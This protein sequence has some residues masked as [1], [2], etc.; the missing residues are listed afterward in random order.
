MLATLFAVIL[1]SFIGVGLPDSVLG[2]AWPE[3]YSEFGLPISMAGYIS[4]S[5][6]VGTIISSILSARLINKFGTGLVTAAS[7]LLTAVALFGY[8]FT[9]EPL[10]FFILAVPLGLGAGA[11]DTGLN[12]FV[13]THY[14]AS[15]MCFLHCSYGL[16]VMASPLIMSIALRGGGWRQGYIIVALIQA[17]ITLITFISLPMW[18]KA[19]KTDAQNLFFASKALTLKELV[20]I[21]GVVYSA[22][23]F[24][25]ICALEL[26]AGG[27]CSS[28]FVNTRGI[29]SENAALITMLFYIGFILGRLISGFLADR[30]GSSILLKIS[31]GLIIPSVI[32][33]ALPL[34]IPLS[35]GALFFTGMAIGPIYPNLM[36]LTPKLFGIETA[37]AV[38]G[39]Q[40]SA[41]YIGIMAAPWLFGILAD[42]FSTLLLPYFLLLMLIFYIITLLA[43]MKTAKRA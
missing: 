37:G 4:A 29:P 11:V 23:A 42:S 2:V 22:L 13:A 31:A 19:E 25:F 30:V 14:S 20:K 8:A 21:P 32:L 6:S 40:Q 38:I 10:F 24:L 12:A 18:K 36:H 15:S 33:F 7:T 28:Y 43:L 27:W 1:I 3:M 9:C 5:V 26:T 35:G 39:F 34:P 17:V 16:G 41:T